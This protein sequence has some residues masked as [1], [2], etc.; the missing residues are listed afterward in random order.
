MNKY[1]S[2]CM[3]FKHKIQR[4]ESYKIEERSMV[5]TF[6]FITDI[7]VCHTFKTSFKLLMQ[8]TTLS[9]LVKLCAKNPTHMNDLC[10]NLFQMG[11]QGSLPPPPD[12]FLLNK[13]RKL[14]ILYFL[15]HS[16]QILD[17]LLNIHLQDN[18]ASLAVYH[19]CRRVVINL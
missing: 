7:F 17:P 9:L 18:S 1:K 19:Q 12:L 13:S 3:R 10:L 16:V 14:Q 15:A 5:K 4:N 6:F 11:M 2:K 8:I